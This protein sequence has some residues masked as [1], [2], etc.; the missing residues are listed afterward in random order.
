VTGRPREPVEVGAVAPDF[1]LRDQHGQDVSLSGL[2][3]APVL[4]VFYPWAF[5]RVCTGELATL[6]DVRRSVQDRGARLLA[7]SC[8]P[9]YSLRAFAETERLDF[10]LLS[11]FWPHGEVASAYG[12]LDEVRGCPRRSSFLVDADGI[13]HWSVH[14]EVSEPREVDAHLAALRE[15][16][17]PR[18][19]GR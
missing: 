18:L 2:R 6:R 8:D 5:S 7:L 19:G 11:D 17:A 16:Q 3:G 13:V 4:L 12:V 9:V 15:L 10:P 14:H 1:R